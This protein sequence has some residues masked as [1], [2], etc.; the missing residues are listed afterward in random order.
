M[1]D[2][3][4]AKPRN[5]HGPTCTLN[6]YGGRPSNGVCK[7]C[8]KREAR[9]PAVPI[10]IQIAQSTPNYSHLSA[11]WGELHRRALSPVADPA[12][13]LQWLDDFVKRL[14]C[15]ECKTHWR[16]ITGAHPPDF[17]DYFEWGVAR[18]NDVNRLLGKPEILL[19]AARDIWVK[20]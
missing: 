1:V 19:E 7:H 8:T 13:E 15:G 11:M 6:L 14:P 18:H 16:K 3:I 5:A 12:A 17:S 2:C 20:N 4:H 9:N 10:Q